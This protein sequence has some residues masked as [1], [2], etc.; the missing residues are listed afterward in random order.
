MSVTAMPCPV[1]IKRRG[2]LYGVLATL[3]LAGLAVWLVRAVV[4]P[5]YHWR[6]AGEAVVRFEPDEAQRHLAFCLAAWPQSSEVHLVAARADRLAGDSEAAEAQLQECER[7]GWSQAVVLER[8]LLR[9]QNGDLDTVEAYLRH[10][11]DEDHP[12]AVFILDALSQG[13]LRV[14]RFSLAQY[15]L[16]L[17]LE[18]QSGNPRA[19]LRRARLWDSMHDYAK[20]AEDFRHV[21]ESDGS[22]TE[23]RLGL[24]TALLELGK[25]ED[26]LHELEEL[27]QQQPDDADTLVRLAACQNMLNR[28]EE[29]Q[30]T[31]D[32]VLAQ[33][34][35]LTTALKGRA[36]VALRQGK[37]ADAESWAR[38]ALAVEPFDFQ[39]NVL[40]HDC[41]KQEGKEKEAREQSAKVEG[42]KTS[43]ARMQQLSTRELQAA[44]DDPAVRF[45]MG[46]LCLGLGQQEAGLGWLL[47]AVQKAPEYT[48][49]HA[50]LA[51]YYTRHGD[52]SRAAYHRQRATAHTPGTVP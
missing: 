30:A 9:A 50:A 8:A 10:Q 48:P 16:N 47:S 4:L 52:S 5:R 14:Y 26:A 25:P 32:T 18:R 1:L 17:W 45:E 11:L 39:A 36:Q 46:M 43:I 2:L 6:A 51:D 49:A 37:P 31:L 27:R 33:H 23:A 24:A 7:L 29:A 34:P 38:K 21:L 40:L 12:D 41:L 35:R 20:A 28:P 13:Y 42:I 15:C 44:P 19:L 3:L 22:R